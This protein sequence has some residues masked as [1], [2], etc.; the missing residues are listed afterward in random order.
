MGKYSGKERSELFEKAL[1]GKNV[2]V[3]TLDSKWYRLLS[4]AGVEDVTE[5][6]NRLN[7][8]LKR[9]GKINTETKDIKKIKK[10]LMEEVVTLADEARTG[11]ESAGKKLEDNK[12]LIAECNDQLAQYDDEILDLPGQID[13]VNRELMIVTMEHCYEIMQENTDEIKELEEWIKNVRI[14]LKKN[15]IRKQEKETKNHE[16]YSYMHDVFG[17][18]VM[19]LFDL[20]YDPEEQHPHARTEDAPAG[21]E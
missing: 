11:D 5:L 8:L 2:P 12:R 20:R 19:S 9:Q 21:S 16:I 10:R 15:L 7:T 3:L 13:E 1:Q 6:E 18:Q 4:R 14:E 17:A